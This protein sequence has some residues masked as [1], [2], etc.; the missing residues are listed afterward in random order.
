MYEKPVTLKDVAEKSDFSLR[1]V[2]K[3]LAGDTTVR[4]QTRENVLQAARELGYKKNMVAS[5]LATNRVW[6]IAIIVGDFRYFFPEAIKSFKE[7]HK[8]WRSLKIGIE[9]FVVGE[10]SRRTARDVLADVL[11]NDRFDAVIM[12]ASSMEGLNQEINALVDAGKAVCTFG[13]DAPGSKRLF[14]VGPR[15][16]ESGRIAAQ[17]TANYMGGSG[18]VCVVSQAQDEMQTLERNRGFRDFIKEKHS[19][20]EVRQIVI[21]GGSEAYYLRIK[22]FL[23]KTEAVGIVGMDADC[24]LAGMAA[25]DCGRKDIFTLGFDLTPE[26]ERLLE[27][28]YFKVVLSQNP[29]LQ[30]EIVLDKLCRYLLYG[31]PV[32]N[33]FT[34]VTIVTSEVLRYRSNLKE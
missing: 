10:R 4:P 8:T 16:Y 17:I 21:E 13:A 6:N 18:C 34:D 22:E 25:R 1:T 33:V 32:K 12:H 5:V 28:D 26:T 23:Q 29:E 2:K 14:F 9:F 24:Y 15:A 30:A 27:E 7:R 11:Q 3:V 20:I 19:A 31:T